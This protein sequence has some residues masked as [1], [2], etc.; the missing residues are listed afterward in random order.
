MFK[1]ATK[2]N[3][4]LRLAI[5]GPAGSGK[6]FSGLA[7]ATNLGSSVAVIDTEHGSSSR[8]ADIFDFDVCCLDN[9]HPAQYINAINE[10]VRA[11]YDLILLDSL[12]HA[13]FAELDLVDKAKNKFTAWAPVRELERKLI[14]TI[15]SC[16][17]HVIATMRTKTEWDTTQTDDKGK[18]KPVKIGTAPIQSSGIEYEFD[19][20]IRSCQNVRL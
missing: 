11:G 14:D 5:S 18:M 15:I 2:T 1:K 3:L 20:A 16:P 9:F 12:S 19:S 13:W 8:Y 4:K 17:C 10:A 6:T 7:I